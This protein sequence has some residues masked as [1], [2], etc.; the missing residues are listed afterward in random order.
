MSNR[1]P[2]S[3]ENRRGMILIIFVVS[4]IIIALAVR[5]HSLTEKNSTYAQQIE[6]LEQKIS[7][8][9]GRSEN[10]DTFRKYTHTNA[11]VEKLAREKLGLVYPE[12]VI[13]QP[14]Q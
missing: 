5:C 4:I 13:F 8:E 12:E 14:R 1:Y 9:K 3:R 6:Q 2:V 10:I 7:E 11:F